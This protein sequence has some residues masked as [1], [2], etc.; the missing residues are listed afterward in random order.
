MAGLIARL[1][2]W[3]PGATIEHHHRVLVDHARGKIYSITYETIRRYRIALETQLDPEV[4]VKLP[5][6]YRTVMSAA[7]DPQTGHILMQRQQDAN[8]LHNWEPIYKYDHDSLQVIG[9]FGLSDT[10]GPPWPVGLRAGNTSFVCVTA[11][12]RSYLVGLESLTL[13]CFA[14]DV[15][16]MSATT[17]YQSV[18]THDLGFTIPVTYTNI[19]AGQSGPAGATV[20]FTFENF[21]VPAGTSN[22]PNTVAV[23]RVSISSGGSF[24]TN[25]GWLFHAQ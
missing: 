7:I 24:S 9:Q 16:S 13:K 25:Y 15:G 2:M 21:N 18:P 22:P 4:M 1:R 6:P 3:G 5:A 23:F 20:F 10:Y 8:F 19:V 14:I 11:G 17:F 12:S